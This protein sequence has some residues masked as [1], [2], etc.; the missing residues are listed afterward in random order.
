MLVVREL[1][2]S[3]NLERRRE[4]NAFQVAVRKDATGQEVTLISRLERARAEVNVLQSIAARK[5][6]FTDLF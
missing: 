4:D 3:D 6:V 2:L 1:I 5:G